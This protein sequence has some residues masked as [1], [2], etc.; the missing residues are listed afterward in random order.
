MLD[1]NIHRIRH[2]INVYEVMHL[3]KEFLFDPFFSNFSSSLNNLYTDFITYD[4]RFVMECFFLTVTDDLESAIELLIYGEPTIKKYGIIPID[5]R[6]RVEFSTV[7]NAR[8]LS[9][10]VTSLIKRSLDQKSRSRI[11]ELHCFAND[12]P[13]LVDVFCIKHDDMINGTYNQRCTLQRFYT[14]VEYDRYNESIFNV[15]K[16]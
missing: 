10:M 12:L 4:K 8:E 7:D 3:F 9:S 14:Y 5:I 15:Y 13:K 6:D 11:K 2:N 16:L 1:K